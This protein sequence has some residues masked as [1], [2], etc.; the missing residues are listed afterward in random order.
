MMKFVSKDEFSFDN[1]GYV[2]PNL[3]F[4]SDI[5]ILQKFAFNTQRKL[6]FDTYLVF[7]KEIQQLN[8]DGFIQWVDGSF[9]SQK[10]NPN[11]ID[12]VTFF[13]I[14]FYQKNFSKLDSLRDK[15]PNL[16][17]FFRGIYPQNHEYY[18][19]SQLEMY[20]WYDLFGWD[21]E[22]KPKGFIEL[23]F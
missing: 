11:D 19:I 18:N 14:E 21:R 3:V 15:F 22:D 12:I 8:P 6:L 4:Q 5:K 17:L 23:N 7:I 13:E 20:Y 1:N 2:S 16:D 9:I 10:Q